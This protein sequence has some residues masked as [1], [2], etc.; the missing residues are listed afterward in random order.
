MKI[1]AAGIAFGA[2]TW[3][4]VPSTAAEEAPSATLRFEERSVA[5][6]S[7]HHESFDTRFPIDAISRYTVSVGAVLTF[8]LD[9]ARYGDA[10][11][12]PRRA[13]VHL[14]DNGSEAGPVSGV[15]PFRLR[16]EAWNDLGRV[17]ARHTGDRA[18]FVG[19]WDNMQRLHLH[20]GRRGRPRYP[21]AGAYPRTEQRDLWGNVAGG[22]L[23][24][25]SL[26]CLS[27]HLLEQADEGLAGIADCAWRG[28]SGPV[29]LL[30]ST[31]DLARIQE[32][33]YLAGRGIPLETRVFSS[34]GDIHGVVASVNAW[35]G[36]GDGTGSY[37]VQPAPGFAV[38]AW[39]VTEEAFENSLLV[40]LLPFSSSLGRDPPEGTKL[41]YQSAA[42]A[43]L[44]VYEISG[45]R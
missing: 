24:D 34:E 25:D 19:W 15:E 43:Y 6:E 39:K 2:L 18:M 28:E 11:D 41:V 44:S 9:V 38:R 37:L 27:R 14:S 36:H 32:M 22:F 42:G 40:R 31:D 30:V 23:P 8:H 21:D 45:S 17:V 5:L 35:A 33:S 26:A 10:D 29:F 20:T 13:I 16:R 1:V 12:V 4:W 3:G 7:R